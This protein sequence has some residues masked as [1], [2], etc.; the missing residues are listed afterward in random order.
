MLLVMFLL[1]NIETFSKVKLYIYQV[2]E[3]DL[4]NSTFLH[5]FY[6]NEQ[7]INTVSKV[8]VRNGYVL[9]VYLKSVRVDAKIK[10]IWI[11][12]IFS[13]PHYENDEGY[14]DDYS[15]E[16]N[17]SYYED[18]ETE[19]QIEFRTRNL[20]V[21]E[22]YK[23]WYNYSHSQIRM[24]HMNPSGT[25]WKI[26]F[27]LDFLLF[28]DRNISEAELEN[29]LARATN[30]SLDAILNQN[31]GR[32]D[33]GD[34]QF[35]GSRLF[36]SSRSRAASVNSC[37]HFWGAR[38]SHKY[39]CG[40]M[41]A[42]LPSE[43]IKLPPELQKRPSRQ[44]RHNFP[45]LE[46]LQKL[47]R[48]GVGLRTGPGRGG[49]KPRRPGEHIELSRNCL[50]EISRRGHLNPLREL[51]SSHS[52]SVS[53]REGA[54]NE[55]AKSFA[56]LRTAR[57]YE[58]HARTYAR[59]DSYYFNQS[60]INAVSKSNANSGYAL[61]ISLTTARAVAEIK[62]IWIETFVF[63]FNSEYDEEFPEDSSSD[64]Y[65]IVW[66]EDEHDSYLFNNYRTDKAYI[67]M[68]VSLLLISNS[69]INKDK[70]HFRT[71][72]ITTIDLNQDWYNYTHSEIDMKHTNPSDSQ[73][74][75][76]FYVDFLL[77]AH[78]N[79][80]DDKFHNMLT[81]RDV[82]THTSILLRELRTVSVPHLSRVTQLHLPL[83]PLIKTIIPLLLTRAAVPGLHS[84][85]GV[86]E[87]NP[88]SD[89]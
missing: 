49:Q 69:S 62:V 60:Y 77:F 89:Y 75:I 42:R 37:T 8:Y 3:V 73:W 57:V 67:T 87:V 22:L 53:S 85:M 34:G 64:H 10:V 70:I 23:G 26:N 50:S 39:H 76:N 55:E 30:R 88:R 11:E 56:P 45:L 82:K 80:S 38:L 46:W 41:I 43:S 1:M 81:K 21:V 52:V 66:L 79:I 20:T 24:K 5:S 2:Y 15:Y 71:T 18:D 36:E 31:A 65:D 14:E 19:D 16:D 78:R 86:G 63:Q 84:L 7:Y 29:M 35:S 12:S 40:P 51:L 59:R 72:N 6:F 32:R 48:A 58:C 4:Y 68:N 83:P 9:E 33:Q 27:Y 17:D 61:D 25:Q 74:K 13:K 44:P 28:A 54:S 47:F